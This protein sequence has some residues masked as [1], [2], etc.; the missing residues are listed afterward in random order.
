MPHALSA[1]AE[2]PV[3]WRYDAPGR[4]DLVEVEDVD[5]DGIDDIMLVAD[6]I[7][8]VLVGPDGIPKWSTPYQAQDLIQF[9]LLVS[10]DNN[11]YGPFGILLGTEQHLILLDNDGNERWKRTLKDSLAQIARIK[12]TEGDEILV[13][14]KN[15]EFLRYSGSG[16]LLWQIE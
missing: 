9:L 3:Y 13:A 5:R 1:Q 15:G 2:T 8:L 12:S 6:G 4:I 14:L 10:I 16:E 7:N 11:P